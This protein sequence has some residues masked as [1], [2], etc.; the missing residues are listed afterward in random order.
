MTIH[1]KKYGIYVTSENVSVRHRPIFT[2]EM[3]DTLNILTVSFRFYLKHYEIN[4]NVTF[5]LIQ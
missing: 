2:V 3:K 4:I 1:C 5:C